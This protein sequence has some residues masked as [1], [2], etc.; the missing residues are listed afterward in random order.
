MGG[1]KMPSQ[2]NVCIQT[3]LSGLRL[4]RRGKVRDVYEFEDK[5]LIIATDRISAF[6]VV[7]PT[8]IPMKGAVLTQLSQF[9][10]EMMKDIAPH[11]L[12]SADA[13]QFPKELQKFHEILNLRSMLSVKAEMFPVEC[14][15]R[16]YL[17][18]SGWKEYQESGSVCGISLP[19]G[20]RECD[21]LP[22]PIFTPATKAETGHDM[23]I[24]FDEACKIVGRDNAAKLKDLT[25][26]IYNRAVDYALAKG[27]MIADVKFEFG[28]YNG[29]IILC[30]E[31]LTPDSSRFWPRANY[32]PGRPQPS[33]DKQF[34]RD[35]LEQ[36]HFDK[37]PPG[38]ELP[39][40]VVQGTMEKYL[41]AYR[42]LSGKSL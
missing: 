31:L 9:W 26:K 35:Y 16:G 38:P 2:S 32:R 21:R 15:A 23:N 41:E 39:P 36:I 40:S 6:D 24:S 1:D 5:L 30:D 12:I 10:F 37:K 27:I 11:H 25:I 13:A 22:E 18:G 14:V 8:P 3:D 7:L 17:T 19:S 42:L 4:L 29:E 33:F 20:L 28:T 34:V